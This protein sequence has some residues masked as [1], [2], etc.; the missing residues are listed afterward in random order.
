MGTH[1]SRLCGEDFKIQSSEDTKRRRLRH[2]RVVKE[3][4]SAE[5]TRYYHQPESVGRLMCLVLS[6]AGLWHGEIV[7]EPLESA[8]HGSGNLDRG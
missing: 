1:L 4:N 5:N 6:V 8:L 3:T 7:V 2:K